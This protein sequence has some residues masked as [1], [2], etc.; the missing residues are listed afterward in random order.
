MTQDCILGTEGPPSFVA[1]PEPLVYLRKIDK[2]LSLTLDQLDEGPSPG[3][4]LDSPTR[5]EAARSAAGCDEATD[6]VIAWS[7]RIE[8][9]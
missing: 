5:N 4:P 1:C 6:I 9:L 7:T 2:P 8:D 3:A